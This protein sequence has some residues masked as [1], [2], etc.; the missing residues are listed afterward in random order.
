MGGVSQSAAHASSE[1]TAEGLTVAWKSIGVRAQL[2][3]LIEFAL[4]HQ[5]IAH[6]GC[7]LLQVWGVGLKFCPTNG[8]S[9]AQHRF[10]LVESI[11]RHKCPRQL[12]QS[13]AVVGVV[14]AK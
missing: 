11:H 13:A 9:L 8:V 3:S 5:D 14:S 7:G 12:G 10:R 2:T 6:S 1:L 4:A